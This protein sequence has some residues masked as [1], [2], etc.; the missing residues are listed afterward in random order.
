VTRAS[1]QRE[2]A[3]PAAAAATDHTSAARCVGAI[4]QAPSGP[5]VASIA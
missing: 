4:V 2:R 1:D 5:S 3:E